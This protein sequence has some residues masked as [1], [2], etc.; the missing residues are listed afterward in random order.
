MEPKRK[1]ADGNMDMASDQNA[2]KFEILPKDVPDVVTLS[3]EV[4]KSDEHAEVENH[5]VDEE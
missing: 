4:V 5:G 2:P 1:D 3:A